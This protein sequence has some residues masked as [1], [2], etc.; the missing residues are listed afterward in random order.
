MHATVSG[1]VSITTCWPTRCE[2]PPR[3]AAT[4]SRQ[5]LVG[6]A[7]ASRRRDPRGLRRG[8][9]RSLCLELRDARRLGLL[10]SRLMEAISGNLG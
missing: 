4:L 5:Q 6:R 9:R 2:P 3:P 10:E 7:S 1:S 8:D